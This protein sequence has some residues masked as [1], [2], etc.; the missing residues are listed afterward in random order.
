M[1]NPV[2]ASVSGVK[3]VLGKMGAFFSSFASAEEPPSV[4]LVPPM[5]DSRERGRS[6]FAKSSYDRCGGMRGRV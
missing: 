5:L 4:V 2:L 1:V 6:R 3:Y